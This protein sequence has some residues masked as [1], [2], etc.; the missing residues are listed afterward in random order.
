MEFEAGVRM[1]AEETLAGA[2]FTLVPDE[3]EPLKLLLKGHVQLHLCFFVFTY[4]SLAIIFYLTH[5]EAKKIT[6][7][8][9]K[10]KENTFSDNLQ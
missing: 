5:V 3:L 7:K 8:L 1:F 2:L 6:V 4:K 10:I 9:L